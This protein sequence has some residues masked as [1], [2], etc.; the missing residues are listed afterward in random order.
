MKQCPYCRGEIEE[1]ALKCQ[2]CGEWVVP[3]RDRELDERRPL[4]LTLGEG[5][6]WYGA[7]KLGQAAIAGVIFLVIL[8]LI[9]L[10]LA[11]FFF[12]FFFVLLHPFLPAIATVIVVALMVLCL[13]TL[14]PRY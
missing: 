14:R 9:F 7:F 13:R 4:G 6:K 5:L 11:V 2:H 3:P 10:P 1:Q 12:P 8:G